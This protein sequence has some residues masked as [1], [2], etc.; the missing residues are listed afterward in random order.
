[1]RVFKQIDIGGTGQLTVAQV[2]SRYCAANHPDVKSG[3]RSENEMS[4]EFNETFDQHHKIKGSDKV[5]P[6]EFIDYY[7]YVS[8]QI[9]S[10]A[11]FELIMSNSWNV[12]GAGGTSMPFAG[13]SRKVTAVNAREAYRNDHHRNLFGTDKVTPFVSKAQ[14]DWQTSNKGNFQAPDTNKHMPTAGGSNL[15]CSGSDDPRMAWA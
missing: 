4:V 2:K 6:E 9:D 3:K 15:A 10:D 8:T 1:M 5:T 13:S 12:S 7:S 11:Q 14:T